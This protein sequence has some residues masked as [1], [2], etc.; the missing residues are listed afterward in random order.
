MPHRE[1]DEVLVR[2]LACG[3]CCTDR[4]VIDGELPVHRDHVIPGHQVVGD[5]ASV[6]SPVRSLAP[7]N[8]VGV[9]WLRSSCGFSE[10]CRSG[11]ENL[12]PDSSYIGWDF[13]GECAEYLIVAIAFAYPLPAG[14][15]PIR[16]APLLCTGI[17]GYRAF[18]RGMLLPGGNLGLYGLG[19]SAHLTAQIAKAAVAR[20]SAITR[21]AADQEL[22]RSLG[23]DFVGGQDATPDVLL[24]SAIIFTPS[25]QIVPQ[26]LAAT[27][28]GGTVVIACIHMSDI[29]AM[30]YKGRCSTSATS[31][32]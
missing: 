5:V 25:G 18:E 22:A 21:G 27:K 9:A 7:G 2:V 24:D 16:T 1:P 12:C 15:D 20:I 8:L 4:H 11:R 19:S 17:I 28:R 23:V 13:D 26:A 6:G 32:R 29:S 14:T 3:V 31:A 30:N 10:W